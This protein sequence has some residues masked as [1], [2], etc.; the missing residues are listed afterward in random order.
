MSTAL[1]HS[2]LLELCLD[3]CTPATLGALW[4]DHMNYIAKHQD[5]DG[6]EKWGDLDLLQQDAEMIHRHLTE[7]HFKGD[8][9]ATQAYLDAIDHIPW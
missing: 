3:L 8:P 4:H 2:D 1:A 5:A 6:S 7:E 9:A